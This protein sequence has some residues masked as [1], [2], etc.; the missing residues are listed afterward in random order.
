M[1]WR[2]AET[3]RGS[4]NGFASDPFP[5]QCAGADP[6]SV[7]TDELSIP[8]SDFASPGAARLYA[9]LSRREVPALDG[10]VEALRTHYRAIDRRRAEVM[11]QRFEVGV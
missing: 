3:S 2:Q 11:V 1:K 9:A 4:R 5:A 10:D 8:F 6:G 7:V